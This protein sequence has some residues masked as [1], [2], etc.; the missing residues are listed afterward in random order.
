VDGCF[1][2]GCPRHGTKPKNR[3]AFWLAK[4]TGNKARDRKVNCLL[5]AKGWKVVRVWE[6]ELKRRDEAKL[7]RRLKKLLSV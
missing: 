4:L 7:V 3:A 6:H 5:R 1:W 2:H